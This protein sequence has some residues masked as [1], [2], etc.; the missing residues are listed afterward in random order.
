[1]YIPKHFAVT[2]KE[3][4]FGFI[5]N[6]S[7]GQLI[8]QVEGRSF[9]THMPF[10]L[11]R[12]RTKLL[13]HIAKANPQWQHLGDQEVLISLQGTHG[14]ISPSWYRAEGVPTWNYQ[15]V[16]IYGQASSYSDPEQ[17]KAIVESLTA[18]NEK[19]FEKPWQPT[20]MASKLRGIVGIEI[21]ISEIQCKYKLGQNRDKAE[22]I[23]VA[24]SLADSGNI[25]L[26]R[27]MIDAQE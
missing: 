6:N 26:S 23:G 3:E 13:G 25:A 2:D 18:E 12:D 15:S 4:I 27:A 7:F 10:L 24:N 17:L 11:S 9:S 14:Y 19:G 22:Q 8:S 20:Y 5:E 1:M 16:H 21:C